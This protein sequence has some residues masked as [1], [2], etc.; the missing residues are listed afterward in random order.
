M[1][2]NAWTI[3]KCQ[4]LT[5]PEFSS[6]S[7]LPAK[8]FIRLSSSQHDPRCLSLTTFWSMYVI[9][10]CLT[11]LCCVVWDVPNEVWPLPHTGVAAQPRC[12]SFDQS[13]LNSH[14]D[15]DHLILQEPR[16]WVLDNNDYDDIPTEHLQNL[17]R[18]SFESIMFS[19]LPKLCS[20]VWHGSCSPRTSCF[21]L[22]ELIEVWSANPEWLK[23]AAGHWWCC[24]NLDWLGKFR[25]N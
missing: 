13:K 23:L 16:I 1:I 10:K 6:A 12:W 25:L 22:H 2:R 7:L 9:D 4:C 11:Q 19:G 5:C 17:T 8:L 24:M 20:Q 18:T 3:S 14:N 15:L 21:W